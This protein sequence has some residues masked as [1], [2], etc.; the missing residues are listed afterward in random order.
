MDTGQP[1]PLRPGLNLIL[2]LLGVQKAGH[3]LQGPSQPFEPT[4]NTAFSLQCDLLAMGPVD[5]AVTFPG[6]PL[7]LEDSVLLQHQHKLWASPVPSSGHLHL[8][9]GFSCH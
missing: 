1:S 6:S 4:R 8:F 3:C 2:F 5:A 7:L 9:S